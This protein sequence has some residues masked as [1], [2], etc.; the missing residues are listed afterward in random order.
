LAC[1]SYEDCMEHAVVAIYSDDFLDSIDHEFFQTDPEQYHQHMVNVYA[2]FGLEMKPSAV[3]ISFNSGKLDAEHSFLGSSAHWSKKYNMY[4]PYPRF[5]KICSS[6][7]FEPLQ[8]LTPINEF[9]RLI[10]LAVLSYPDSIVFDIIIKYAKFLLERLDLKSKLEV[11]VFLDST[12]INLD[13]RNSFL[14]VVTGRE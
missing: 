13:S 4:I 11:E 12:Q 14:R 10:S 1:P 8:P 7:L 2:K 6:L 9:Y 3:K 5:G